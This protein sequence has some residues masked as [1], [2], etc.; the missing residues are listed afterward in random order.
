MKMKHNF[1]FD[2]NKKTEWIIFGI[3]IALY[4]IISFFHEPM[5]DEAQAWMIARDASWYELM[6][7]IPHY[8]G[9]PPFWHLILA[10][11]AKTGIPFEVG[12]R[13]P[14][15]ICW[16]LSVGILLF[17]SPF[18][19]SIKC[20]LPFT[21]YIFFRYGIVVRPYCLTMLGLFL[22][23]ST[24]KKKGEKPFAFMASLLVLCVSSAYGMALAAG[25]CVVWIIELFTRYKTNYL[26]QVIA[27]SALLIFNLGQLF[28]MMPKDDTNSV[29]AFS[30]MTILYGLIYMFILGPA[31]SMFLDVGMDA[32]LQ[33]YAE[34]IITEGVSSY[35][36]LF[37]GLLTIIFLVYY[38]QKYRKLLLLIVPYTVFSLFSAAV[39]FWYHH[40]GIIHLFL[41][42]VF[43][44]ALEEKEQRKDGKWPKTLLNVLA[45]NQKIFTKIPVFMLVLCLGMSLAWNIFCSGTDLFKK[46]WYTKDLAEGIK[47]VGADQ[48]NCALQWDIMGVGPFEN[49]EDYVDASKYYHVASVTQFFDCLAYFDE[50]IFYNHNGGN[51]EISYNMQRVPEAEQQA[52]ILEE[53]ATYGYPEFIIGHAFVLDA[54]PIDEEMPNYA[55]VYRFEVYKPD[56]F[57]IDY[58]DRYI[59]A[60][61]DIYQQRSDWPIVEQLKID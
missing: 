5:Y 54:L 6:F 21:Y 56:K 47:T 61:E 18:P 50:N 35:I 27:L 3:F 28:L 19:K 39:Y 41:I 9:H 22:A 14:G 8:E 43:W 40:I 4:F 23:A 45:K 53:I 29:A 12:L 42:F 10:L 17:R 58:N 51:K 25:I 55:P 15:A 24:Y 16:I 48:Y 20:L 38:A 32:R 11:F 52:L 7:E 57:I 34:G 37:I 13:I 60:R 1:L 26:K 30:F 2:N 31:D 44:C 46:T 49:P 59:Y 33:N 36:N